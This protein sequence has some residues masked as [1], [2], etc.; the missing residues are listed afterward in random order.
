[1]LIAGVPMT[2]PFQIRKIDKQRIDLKAA[3]RR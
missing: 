2:T 1:M 3:A